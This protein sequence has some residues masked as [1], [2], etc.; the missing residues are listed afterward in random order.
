M[1][2]RHAEPAHDDDEDE[3]VVHRERV[4]GQPARE[5]LGAVLVAGEHPDAHA[6]QD[7]Q[8]DEHRQRDADLTARGLVRAP[9]DDEDVEDQDRSGQ[10]DGDPPDPRGDI[11]RQDLRRLVTVV[12][13]DDG[14]GQ[15]EGLSRPPRDRSGP[16]AP[17]PRRSGIRD[18]DTTAKG[19]S[20]PSTAILP[21]RTAEREIP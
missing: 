6:E 4:L 13:T 5:E 17:G 2:P 8:P 20:P 12:R 3:E 7:R 14:M 21:A 9:A 1:A 19:Y 11:H 15:S 10:A 18:D 16:A